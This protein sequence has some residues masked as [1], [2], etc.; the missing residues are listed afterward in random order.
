[1]SDDSLLHRTIRKLEIDKSVRIELFDHVNFTGAL[2][3]AL[4]DTLYL[5]DGA[6]G[7]IIVD[8]CWLGS[9]AFGFRIRWVA[10]FRFDLR[11][12]H[13]WI[14]LHLVNETIFRIRIHKAI[15]L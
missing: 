6:V 8:G 7:G 14:N 3:R 5:T 11:S 12:R 2:T 9:P 1:M 4:G 15:C 13:K 10:L